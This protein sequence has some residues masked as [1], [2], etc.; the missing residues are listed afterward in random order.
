[1]LRHCWIQASQEL[2]INIVHDGMA[3]YQEL[4]EDPSTY[5]PRA[6]EKSTLIAAENSLEVSM[7]VANQILRRKSG[8]QT[9]ILVITGSLHIVSSVLASLQK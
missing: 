4:L 7:K 3:E 9:D 6:S 5:S 8:N 2:G 1:M